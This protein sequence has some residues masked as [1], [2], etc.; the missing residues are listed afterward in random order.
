MNAAHAIGLAVLGGLSIELAF[1]ALKRLN[2]EMPTTNTYM[3]VDGPAGP[4]AWARYSVFRFG[5]PAVGLLMVAVLL[6]KTDVSRP[7]PLVPLVLLSAGVSL[8]CRDLRALLSPRTSHQLKMRHGFV[9]AAVLVLAVVI[10]GIGCSF[11]LQSLAPAWNDLVAN[12]WSAVLLVLTGT[13]F[14][15]LTKTPA[16]RPHRMLDQEQLERLTSRRHRRIARR[17]SRPAADAARTHDVFEPLLHAI[18]IL[19]DI[20]RPW[21][22]RL[23]ENLA[24]CIP[25]VKCTVGIC[26]VGSNRPLSNRQSIEVAAR[27]YLAGS[28]SAF[29]MEGEEGARAQEEIIYEY[30]HSY[31]YV[32]EIQRILSTIFVP[33][34]ADGE[35]SGD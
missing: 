19:E 12:W 22:L 17:Y 18:M 9:A 31:D 13:A 15:V 26:Q 30:N 2:V 33:K 20:N 5:P 35:E 6:Q 14:W 4:V 7:L 28:R 3:G 34:P 10:G 16:E 11:D 29:E 8:C 1:Q 24:V 23:L 32:D 21:P 25:K 27:D